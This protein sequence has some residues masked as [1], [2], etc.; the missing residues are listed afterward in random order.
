MKAEDIGR[1]G[2]GNVDARVIVIGVNGGS[3][4]IVV[5]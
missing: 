3:I 5:I 2:S 1:A 4:L